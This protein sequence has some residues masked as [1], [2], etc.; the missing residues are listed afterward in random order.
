MV[1]PLAFVSANRLAL[2]WPAGE[3]QGRPRCGMPT[4]DWEHQALVILAEVKQTI[5]RQNAVKSV[6]KGERTHVRNE[7]VVAGK[8]A[9]AHSDEGRRRVYAG[10]LATPIDEVAGDWLA[11]T[12]SNVENASLG[13]QE[14]Q[15]PIEPRF[16]KKASSSITIPINRMDL[17]EIDYIIMI[18]FHLPASYPQPEG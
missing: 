7:P 15:H 1:K 18:T 2:R 9:P 5:P 4:E 10:H 12:A 11:G 17:I 16:L 14:R 3:H 13:R 8:T 6:I